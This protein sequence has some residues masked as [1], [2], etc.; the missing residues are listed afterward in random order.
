MT[1]AGS[2]GWIW[3]GRQGLMHKMLRLTVIAVGTGPHAGSHRAAVC[4]QLAKH[5]SLG[6]ETWCSSDAELCRK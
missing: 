5:L 3:M 6:G 1:A 2:P 4:G